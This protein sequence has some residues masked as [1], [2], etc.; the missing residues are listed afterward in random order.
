MAHP[1]YETLQALTRGTL[2]TAQS[3]RAQRHIFQCPDCLKRLIE[4]EMLLALEDAQA[5]P[6]EL[7][8]PD[9]RKPQYIRHDTADGFIYSRV[10]RRGRKWLA[11]HWGERLEGQYE[12]RTMREANEHAMA[13]FA[14]M[15][16]EHRC[17]ERC[18]AD[19][20]VSDQEIHI[21]SAQQAAIIQPLP[22]SDSR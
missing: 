20:P 1:A 16:P 14:Q 17:T 18:S 6:H 8:K 7:P 15:F 2:T 21:P 10:E 4:I 3:L 13:S 19:P 11:R 12:Y 22:R 5:A 9:M